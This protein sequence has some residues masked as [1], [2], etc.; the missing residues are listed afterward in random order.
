M[1]K[2]HKHSFATGFIFSNNPKFIKKILKAFSW[3]N[4]G[5]ANL[6][7][8]LQKYVTSVALHISSPL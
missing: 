8:Y 5:D 7:V 1:C 3:G 4:Q 6:Q 2:Q